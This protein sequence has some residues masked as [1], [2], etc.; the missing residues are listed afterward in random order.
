MSNERGQY[1]SSRV[2]QIPQA[3]TV[4]VEHESSIGSW[5][6]GTIA[7]GGAVLWARHQSQQIEQLYKTA[8]LPQQSFAG[9]LRQ[10]AKELPSRASASLHSLAERVRP[11]GRNG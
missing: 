4:F 8:G 9:S 11:K 3:T 1:S 5:I 10:S 7:V 6:L 2:G